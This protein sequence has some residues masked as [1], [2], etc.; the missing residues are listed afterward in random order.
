MA[1]LAQMS[2]EA[3]FEVSGSD[4]SASLNLLALQKNGAQIFH[5][6]SPG[7]LQ[8]N[9]I[10]VY[11]SAIPPA[12]IEIQEAQNRGL[13]LIHRS[14]WASSLLFPRA[15]LLVV[16]THG[17]T[18]TSSM[19]A[20]TLYQSDPSTSFAVG[21]V[22]KQFGTGGKYAAGKWSVIEGDESDAS[23]LNFFP[24]TVLATNIAADHLD[25]YPDIEAIERTFYSLFQKI[26]KNGCLVYCADDPVLSKVARS[27]NGKKLSYGLNHSAQIIAKN[28][29]YCGSSSLF[30]PIVMG[31]EGE[32]VRINMPGPHNIS[33][34]LGVLACCH[35]IGIPDSNAKMGL[36]LFGGVEQRFE[37]IGQ[38]NNHTFYSDY[39]HNPQ[40]IE[41]ALHGA[42]LS[43]PSHQIIAIFEPH[44]YSRVEGLKNEFAKSFHHANQVWVAPIYA[45]GEAPL[46]SYDANDWIPLIQRSHASVKVKIFSDFEGILDQMKIMVK[47]L[48]FKHPTLFITLGAGKVKSIFSHFNEIK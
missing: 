47:E 5:H 38:I 3:G 8:S 34:A 10:V 26:P 11:S 48:T 44:R 43:F 16:G 21:G 19:L 39:A 37:Y 12:N 6:H 4:T 14:V 13:P 17:K 23:F 18:T 41:A 33:N 1:T 28:I 31:K 32:P 46:E 15:C 22:L 36:E 35:S 7:H 20:S 45:A 27:W 9:P 25:F 40:K 29:Q 30:T 42:R 24:H 2:L